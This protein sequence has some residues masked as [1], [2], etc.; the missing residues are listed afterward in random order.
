MVKELVM[1]L[2]VY[3]FINSI[4][5]NVLRRV[6]KT[7]TAQGLREI[8]HYHLLFTLP[9]ERYEVIIQDSKCT[10]GS[11]DEPY[12]MEEEMIDGYIPPTPEELTGWELEEYLKN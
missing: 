11:K 1:N 12:F 10:I 8:L 4:N 7:T 3:Q 6:R 5:K 2:S 9:K